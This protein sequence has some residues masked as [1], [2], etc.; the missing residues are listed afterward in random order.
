M[1]LPVK[2]SEA[3]VECWCNHASAAVGTKDLCFGGFHCSLLCA[4]TELVLDDSNAHQ[5]VQVRGRRRPGPPQCQ[6]AHCRRPWCPRYVASVVPTTC[7]KYCDIL[8]NMWDSIFYILVLP[9]LTHLAFREVPCSWLTVFI[10]YIRCRYLPFSLCF[11]KKLFRS[12][13]ILGHTGCHEPRITMALEDIKLFGV[14]A[15]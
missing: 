7:V 1:T 15:Q 6:G 5:V 10:S 4:L 11:L 13:L 9:L 2:F 8:S 3:G 14:Y 12:T